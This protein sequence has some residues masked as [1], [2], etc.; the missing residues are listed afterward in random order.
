MRPSMLPP[1]SMVSVLISWVTWKSSA[2][3]TGDVPRRSD[4]RG[5]AARAGLMLGGAG[6]VT[7]ARPGT[8]EP[9]GTCV[10]MRKIAQAAPDESRNL[11]QGRQ[12][13]A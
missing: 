4:E 10:L 1:Y 7:G 6:R 2:V 5:R 9:S 13:V 8:S 12:G 11:A 3:C